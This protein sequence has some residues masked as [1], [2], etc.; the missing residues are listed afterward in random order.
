MRSAS[1]PGRK[2]PVQKPKGPLLT[3]AKE[4]H[5]RMPQRLV[6]GVATFGLLAAVSAVAAAPAEAAAK[7]AAAACVFVN[8]TTGQEGTNRHGLPEIS[9][10]SNFTKPGTSTCHDFNLWSGRV[11]TSYEGWLYYGNG[12]W[13]A[14]NA[15]YV[16]YT[17]GS[18]VL[19][20]N[21]AAG[22]IEAVTSTGGSGQ[23]IEIMD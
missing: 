2:L 23:G 9:G 4:D 21:V 6:T 20:T 8:G 22:T 3:E 13:G 1:A 15:G 19:C 16:K 11:G 12:N 10:G 17:G 5:M 7:P 18:I 14:C